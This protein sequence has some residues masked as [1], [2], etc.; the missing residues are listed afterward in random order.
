MRVDVLQG[1]RTLGAR[2]L[3]PNSHP[4]HGEPLVKA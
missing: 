4:C 3:A 1:S 2:G